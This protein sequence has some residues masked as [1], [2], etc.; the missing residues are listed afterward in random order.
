MLKVS[1]FFLLDLGGDGVFRCRENTYRNATRIGG[2]PSDCRRGS[3]TVND[4]GRRSTDTTRTGR[5]R[6]P[7][8]DGGRSRTFGRPRQRKRRP[9]QDEQRDD[10]AGK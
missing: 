4:C 8:P 9:R 2:F 6:R 5:C 1:F 10:S 7:R 3:M